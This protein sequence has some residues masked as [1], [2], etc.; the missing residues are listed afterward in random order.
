MTRGRRE[1]QASQNSKVPIATMLGVIGIVLSPATL[2]CC[3]RC[4]LLLKIF[5]PRLENHFTR[6]LPQVRLPSVLQIIRGSFP[7]SAFLPLR[8]L[9]G[10]VRYQAAIHQWL[11]YANA[12]L[13]IGPDLESVLSY[14]STYGSSTSKMEGDPPPFQVVI[15]SLLTGDTRPPP[16][17]FRPLSVDEAWRYT[18]LTTSPLPPSGQLPIPSLAAFNRN[19][20]IVSKAERSIVGP[21]KYTPA[22]D[23]ALK[24]LLNPDDLAEM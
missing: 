3:R 17:K 19:A 18:P 14:C 20:R 7:N 4:S 21:I 15:P 9:H 2:T 10:S 23:E 8:S 11:P 5:E 6:Q 24:R 13:H 1:P 16:P 12:S 22:V